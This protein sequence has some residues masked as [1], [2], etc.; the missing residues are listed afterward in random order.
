MLRV[1]QAVG[2]ITPSRSLTG[3]IRA[4]ENR[5]LCGWVFDQYLAIAPPAFVADGPR[6]LT[7]SRAAV[8]QRARLG[9][10]CLARAAFAS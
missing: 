7:R 2:R 3:F 10:R 9:L 8:R 1:Q 6:A 4:F 5:R